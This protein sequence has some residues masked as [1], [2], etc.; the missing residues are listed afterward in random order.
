MTELP[1]I[2]YDKIKKPF[3]KGAVRLGLTANQL[4]VINHVITLTFGCYF[5]SRGNYLCFMGGLAVCII[6]GFIDYLDGDVAR[7]NN[8]QSQLGQWL[9]TGFDVI[10]QNA[11][12]GAIGIGCFKMGMPVFWIVLFFI[13]NSASNFVSF[14]YNHRFGFESSSG[15]GKFRMMMESSQS[16][17][18]LIDP[19]STTFAL[20]TYTCRYWIAL[21]C[22]F[23]IMPECYIAITI[24]SNFRWVIMY[25]IF[26][27]YLNDDT[28]LH[29]LNVLR[30]LDPEQPEYYTVDE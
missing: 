9:D 28:D 13:G 4:T 12:L 16:M 29:V 7:A 11:V 18:D 26:A 14:H 23:N 27:K 21:G 1:K 20:I 24:I 3:V 30:K 25:V 17:R 15:N 6:N 8:E 5:F 10:I 22:L 2:I 19:T